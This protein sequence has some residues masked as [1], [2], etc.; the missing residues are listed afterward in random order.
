MIYW[1][2]VPMGAILFIALLF[3]WGQS[4]LSILNAYVARKVA[5]AYFIAGRK[6]DL[7]TEHLF[8]PVNLA[9]FEID[10]D[11]QSVLSH[12]AGLMPRRA[13]YHP[14]FGSA[15]LPYGQRAS[16]RIISPHYLP[17]MSE[18]DEDLRAPAEDFGLQ[19]QAIQEAVA[20]GFDQKGEFPRKRSRAV[21]IRYKGV[22]I[23]E[24]YAPGFGQETPQL[25]W[26]LTKSWLHALIG[27]LVAQE[28]IRVH[29]PVPIQAWQEDG[30]RE[31][32]W[33]HLLR[34]V[35]G[36][37]WQENY[38]MVSGATR[39]LFETGDVASFAQSC[40]LKHPP[41]EQWVYSSGTSNI[42]SGLLRQ[43][44]ADDTRYWDFPRY[45]L[46][47]KLN[48]HQAL[49]ETDWSGNWVASSLG[50]ATAPAWSRF[51]QL[52]L[53]GGLW[54]GERILPESWVKEAGEVTSA[55]AGEYGVHFWLNQS[56]KL[57]D[58][59]Q[60]VLMAQGFEGQRIFIFP[61]KDLVI[62][63]LGVNREGTFDFN[64]WV[65][66]ILHALDF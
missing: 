28:Q 61:D 65:S 59:P 57:P 40:P 49:I 16:S 5:S 15:L 47:E 20:R 26:S 44:F 32:T 7:K 55:S 17:K 27:M 52:Y 46:F 66:G 31:I 9:R 56:K 60:N 6:E 43:L 58:V 64:S 14:G 62:T 22:I 33:M 39:M 24:T 35:S 4:Y 50:Y 18:R 3:F 13:F 8:F 2:A 25:G 34:M 19:S 30:R 63:R 51:G 54:Q 37:R 21:I 10:P 48:M 38:V 36:L 11:S 12:V 1:L 41:G 45:A 29:E 23:H 42:L 53:D